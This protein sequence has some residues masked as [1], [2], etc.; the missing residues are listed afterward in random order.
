MTASYIFQ[1][2]GLNKLARYVAPDTL[3]AFD[4][5]GTLAPIVE[6]YAAARVAKPVQV[7]LQRL[8]TLAKVVVITGRSRQAAQAILGFEPHLLIGNHG[9]EW[10]S[11]EVNRNWQQI[12]LCL[13]W[14]EQLY[15]KVSSLQGVETEF[16]GESVSVHYRKA[17]NPVQALAAINAAVETLDP[18]PKSI[19]GIFVVNLM[20]AEALTKGDALLAAM[21][22]FGLQRAIFIGDDVTDEA[23][24]RLAD[25]A[26]F[27]IHIGTEGKTA[28]SY[29]LKKQSELPGLLNAMVG[30]LEACT[31][32][33]SS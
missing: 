1:P 26:V 19:D 2:E 27:G 23:V 14:Q 31:L 5:D 16:K 22:L 10:P 28:A 13:K 7:T 18:P 32:P 24:F 15:D 12:G 20:P 33:V 8:V 9:S 6:D 4:L 21:E 17:E 30:M 25:A 29:F 3:F 11:G